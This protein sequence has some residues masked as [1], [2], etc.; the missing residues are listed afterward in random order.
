MDEIKNEFSKEININGKIFKIENIKDGKIN[1]LIEIIDK[2]KNKIC[3]VIMENNKITGPIKLQKNNKIITMG[4]FS[5]GEA[6]KITKLNKNSIEEKITSIEKLEKGKINGKVF[7]E[8]LTNKIDLSDAFLG[9]FVEGI[10][11]GLFRKDTEKA[12]I[13]GNFID[14]KKEG[15]F[16]FFKKK[17]NEIWGINY[18][19]NKLDGQITVKKDNNTNILNTK[20]GILEKK[21]KF[22]VILGFIWKTIKNLIKEILKMFSKLLIKIKL[23]ILSLL[24]VV[25]FPFIKIIKLIGKIFK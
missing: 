8:E 22:Y 5:K 11:T 18:L 19:N 4:N 24:K 7:I 1:G 16:T 3:E 15:I 10:L 25:F 14:N 23:M 20:N 6:I 12:T 9:N 13:D 21:K 17:T 2:E